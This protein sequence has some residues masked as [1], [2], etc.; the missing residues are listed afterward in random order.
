M[1]I[2]KYLELDPQGCCPNCKK[3]WAGDEMRDHVS[4]M[5]IMSNRHSSTVDEMLRNFGYTP[6]KRFTLSISHNIKGVL[7]LECHE[8]FHV[9]DLAGNSF[10]SIEALK[11]DLRN[12]ELAGN[13]SEEADGVFND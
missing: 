3:S 10:K 5:E 13:I 11:D 7:Y 8:C 6:G 4:Q 12:K 2:P 1:S 9:F